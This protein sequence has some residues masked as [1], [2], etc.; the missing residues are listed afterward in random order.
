MLSGSIDCERY[1]D[2]WTAFSR[3]HLDK[4]LPVA[5]AGWY[6][7]SG[8][9]LAATLLT[10]ASTYVLTAVA[11]RSSVQDACFIPLLV[12][13]CMFVVGGLLALLF[14]VFP[15]MVSHQ[16]ST[17][18]IY[19]CSHLHSQNGL[20]SLPAF[21]TIDTADSHGSTPVT[22][23]GHVTQYLIGPMWIAMA[24]VYLVLG[25][26]ATLLQLDFSRAIRR[27]LAT[28]EAL[29]TYTSSFTKPY[30]L[31]SLFGYG[32]GLVMCVNQAHVKRSG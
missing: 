12:T 28:D 16:T 8:D 20:T 31:A 27:A 6:L 30:F 4:L 11:R 3:T 18:P 13:I 10:L 23:D 21:R 2:R 29:P 15:S 25:L 22:L 26:F 7:W 1:P 9:W 14:Y 19:S 32:A 17:A 5:T 24:E